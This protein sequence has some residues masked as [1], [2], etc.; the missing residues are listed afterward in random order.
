MGDIAD[1]L[2]G[3]VDNLFGIVNTLQLGSLVEVDQVF[4]Q[5]EPGGRQERACVVMEV[6]R[7]ALAFFFLQADTGIQEQFLLVL[8]HPLQFHLVPDDLTL[9]KDDKNDKPDRKRQHP[10]SAKK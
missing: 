9:V 10:Y 3:I 2:D 5:I 1:Q 4:V 6:G 7:D 8:F